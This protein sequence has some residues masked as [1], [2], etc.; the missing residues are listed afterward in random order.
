MGETV[1]A[2][3]V[4]DMTTEYHLPTEDNSVSIEDYEQWKREYTWDALVNIRYG[5]S[6]CNHFDRWDWAMGE[7]IFAFECKVDDSWEDAFRSGEH[8]LLWIPVDKDGNQVPK[9]EHKH[10]QM[11]HGPKDTYQCDYEGMKIVETRIQNGFRLFGKYYQ[12]LWD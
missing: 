2:N 1:F 11:T 8:D 3:M 5:Q 9:G 10:Y 6:F 7:M 4:S 12:G